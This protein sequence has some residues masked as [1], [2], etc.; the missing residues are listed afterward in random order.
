MA[1]FLDLTG[2]E[3]LAKLPIALPEGS[4]V[5][6]DLRDQFAPL[7][8]LGV[9]FEL[10]VPAPEVFLGGVVVLV[11][12]FSIEAGDEE[13]K[14]GVLHALQREDE[15]VGGFDARAE[16]IADEHGLTVGRLEGQERDGQH[17]HEGG[18]DHPIADPDPG[19]QLEL[20][21]HIL[22]RPARSPGQPLLVAC[23]NFRSSLRSL[24]GSVRIG[25]RRK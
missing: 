8:G 11:Q 6:A 15:V 9:D 17:E 25:E 19:S 1:G 21:G 23:S 14:L 5:M 4:E 12:Q 18:N 20:H 24:E 3:E 7:R 10:E 13:E 16:A 22:S 2:A